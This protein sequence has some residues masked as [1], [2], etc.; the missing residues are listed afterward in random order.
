MFDSGGTI[1]FRYILEKRK[2]KTPF[3]FIDY[4]FN[5]LIS[6]EAYRHY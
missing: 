4:R 1:L 5:F 3:Y 6:I 2:A